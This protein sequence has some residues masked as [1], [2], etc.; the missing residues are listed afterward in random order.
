MWLAHW[1]SALPAHREGLVLLT[2][3]QFLGWRIGTVARL[4]T[5]KLGIED[6][7]LTLEASHCKNSAR[8]AMPCNKISLSRMPRLFE[9]ARELAIDRKAQG[10]KLLFDIPPQGNLS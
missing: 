10:Y 2:L 1:D 4:E 6:A 9:V 7:A 8:S 3:L 5:A